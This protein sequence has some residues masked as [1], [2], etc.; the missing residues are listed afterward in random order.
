MA[1]KATP[2]PQTSYAEAIAELDEILEAIESGD[3]DI[4]VLSERVARAAELL[5]T[6]R[7]KLTGTELRVK[8]IVEE[9]AAAEQDAGE[10]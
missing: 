4:D 2:L 1:K 5:K 8:K 10:E 7:E 6:C 3:A 9:L